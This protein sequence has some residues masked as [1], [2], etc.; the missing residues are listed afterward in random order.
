MLLEEGVCYD[1]WVFLAKLCWPLSY[2]IWARCGHQGGTERVAW[3]CWVQQEQARDK[4]LMLP[5]GTVVR[6]HCSLGLIPGQGSLSS[7][8]P[9]TY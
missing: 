4:P 3:R 5:G 8:P 1:Q 9:A 7:S 2:F 6:I